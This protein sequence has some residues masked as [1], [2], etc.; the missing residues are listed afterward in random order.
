MEDEKIVFTKLGTVKTNVFE[1]SKDEFFQLMY[2]AI[3]EDVVNNSVN[4][5]KEDNCYEIV[6]DSTPYKVIDGKDILRKDSS[7]QELV[8][9]I[10]MLVNHTKRK[11]NF[12]GITKGE[13]EKTKETEQE[14]IARC[15]Q[16]IFNDNYDKKRYIEYLNKKLNDK[17]EYKEELLDRPKLYKL[18]TYISLVIGFIGMCGPILLLILASRIGVPFA[19]ALATLG[20]IPFAAWNFI[21]SGKALD[22][23]DW[24]KKFRIRTDTMNVTLLGRIVGKTISRRKYKKL[25][26]AVKSSMEKEPK[27]T[28]VVEQTNTVSEESVQKETGVHK[29]IKEVSQ[30]FRKVN[31]IVN[32]VK[33]ELKK[34]EYSNELLGLLDDYKAK[35]KLLGENGDYLGLYKIVIDN[36]FSLTY[37][38]NETL[39]E[40]EQEKKNKEEFGNMFDEVER[41]ES[42]SSNK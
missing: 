36:L 10:E 14:F 26:K 38:V 37:R 20:I 27:T 33:S 32:Q 30:E 17:D 3:T 21:L 12:L 15:K 7:N 5:N 39:K 24:A 16:G 40:E 23:T 13:K 34:K 29:T 18:L 31:N 25:I 42:R 9:F 22:D 1:H 41:V 6:Y 35:T 4:Y 11:E 2:N 28:K 8:H 19:I